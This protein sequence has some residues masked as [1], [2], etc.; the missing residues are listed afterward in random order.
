MFRSEPKSIPNSNQQQ[1]T[2]FAMP[3]A[4]PHRQQQQQ[5]LLSPLSSA[6]SSPNSFS[7]DHQHHHH[8]FDSHAPPVKINRKRVR[9]F[10]P[11][12]Q[13][14]SISSV[15]SPDF[16][17][18]LKT[19]MAAAPHV[20]PKSQSKQHHKCESPTSILRQKMRKLSFHSE[21]GADSGLDSGLDYFSVCDSED[22]YQSEHLSSHQRQKHEQT[23]DQY[24]DLPLL[25]ENVESFL[26]FSIPP[27]KPLFSAT[28][29]YAPHHLRSEPTMEIASSPPSSIASSYS[30]TQSGLFLSSPPTTSPVSPFSKDVASLSSWLKSQDRYQGQPDEFDEDHHDIILENEE[31]SYYN[32]DGTLKARMTLDMDMDMDGI[33]MYAVQEDDESEDEETEEEQVEQLDFELENM[34]MRIN[35]VRTFTEVQN[36]MNRWDC[37]EKDA[38]ELMLN[39]EDHQ[40]TKSSPIVY[41]DDEVDQ[42]HQVVPFE[43]D[44]EPIQEDYEESPTNLQNYQTHVENAYS[45][46]DNMHHNNNFDLLTH[47]ININNHN[48]HNNPFH[49][50]TANESNTILT[51]SL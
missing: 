16:G 10:S 49:F 2:P 48:H 43:S 6:Y 41:K 22:D 13:P 37:S 33:T 9:R 7:S 12:H 8:L 27:R 46:N 28:P 21:V 19:N 18:M 5:H 17:Y 11:A 42:S 38:L 40:N 31:D 14:S 20:T 25:D 47:A 50:T 4:M 34:R 26:P 29:Q 36:V 23:N 3:H 1:P 30:S 35:G 24:D 44:F 51:T 32:D 39:V 15:G 45:D